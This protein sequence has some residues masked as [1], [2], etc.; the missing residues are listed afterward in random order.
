[1]FTRLCFALVL[2]VVTACSTLDRLET[3]SYASKISN[4]ERPLSYL[5][6]L[7]VAAL[8]T[9]MRGNSSNG[10][11]YDSNYF[12]PDQSGGYKLASEKAPERYTVRI[13][14]LGDERPYAMSVIVTKER[15]ILDS[16]EFTYQPNGHDTRMAK[17]LAGKIRERLSKRREELNIIDDFRAY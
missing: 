7:A 2:F 13:T 8:P 10:R 9:G 5:Q 1:M 4:I 3:P 15:R 6:R 17:E 16:G 14:V 12:I 11:E